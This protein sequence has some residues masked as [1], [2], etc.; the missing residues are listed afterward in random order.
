MRVTQH[1]DDVVKRTVNFNM[2]PRQRKQ[3]QP[4]QVQCV[5]IEREIIT[6]VCLHVRRELP[7]RRR[8]LCADE[9]IASEFVFKIRG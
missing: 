1:N 6:C 3:V 7:T 2:Q 4:Q 9:A 8:L 5:T